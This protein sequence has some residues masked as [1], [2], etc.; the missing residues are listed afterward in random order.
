MK[1]KNFT[2]T[3]KK[4]GETKNYL[5]MIL[6][7]DTNHFGGID[8]TKL[9]EK[10][11]SEIVEIQKQYEKA[12]RPFEEKAYRLFLKGNIVNEVDTD[13]PQQLPDPK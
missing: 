7:E 4:D 6:N 13:Y 10:E 11:I 1:F 2:Y 9:N 8:L 3:K 12:I 5:V